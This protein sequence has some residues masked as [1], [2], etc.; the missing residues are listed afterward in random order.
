MTQITNRSFNSN[1]PTESE[2]PG[3][4]IEGSSGALH[5]RLSNV[6]HTEVYLPKPY[7]NGLYIPFP[8]QYSSPFVW[9]TE[10]TELIRGSNFLKAI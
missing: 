2:L 6:S 5:W 4:F 8:Y 9:T 1:S 7:I 3:S 10:F